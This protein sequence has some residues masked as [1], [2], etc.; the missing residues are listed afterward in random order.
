MYCCEGMLLIARV[1]TPRSC[2]PLYCFACSQSSDSF[3][4]RCAVRTAGATYVCACEAK[5]SCAICSCLVSFFH[6]TLLGDKDTQ[7]GGRSWLAVAIGTRILAFFFFSSSFSLLHH[8]R[9]KS[10]NHNLVV[11]LKRVCI[12]VR[13]EELCRA[14]LFH[15]QSKVYVC[16]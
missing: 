13:P 3:S 11:P 14:F 7:A 6:R 8:R 5:T 15:R 1:K 9:R 4:S 12:D 10:V 16:N 2:L